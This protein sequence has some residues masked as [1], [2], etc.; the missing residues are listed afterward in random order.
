[1]CSIYY[2]DFGQKIFIRLLD[3]PFLPY[4][5]RHKTIVLMKKGLDLLLILCVFCLASCHRRP[6]YP[7]VLH[8]ADSLTYVAP[9]QA[10]QMLDSINEEMT[11]ADKP[12]R[13]YHQL[14]TVKAKDKA[15]IT[16]TSD[17]LMLSLVDYYE[18]GGDKSLLPEAYYYLG[19][20]YRDLNDAPRAL[21]AFQKAL[22]AV[23]KTP[24]SL[25]RLIHNQ[26]GWLYYRQK[27]YDDA[28]NSY[29]EGYRCDSLLK[30]SFEMSSDLV[31]IA[32]IHR[33]IDSFHDALNYLETAK[34][35][36]TKINSQF[37]LD[38]VDAQ[39]AAA[40]L[41]IGR[42]E[43]AKQLLQSPLKHVVRS[44][45]S[46][47]YSN[48]AKAYLHVGDK[49]SAS[50]YF[51]RVLEVGNI[52]AKRAAY[53]GLGDIALQSGHIKEAAEY[54]KQFKVLA[55]SAHQI[56]ASESVAQMKSL[57]DYQL[58]EKENM[59]LEARNSR[60]HYMTA[61]LICIGIILALSL[62][63]YHLYMQRKKALMEHRLQMM[64]DENLTY[65]HQEE[66][67]N[68]WKSEAPNLIMNSEVYANLERMASQ[69][70]V[71]SAEDWKAVEALLNE[72][73]PSYIPHL[74]ASC[75]MS[76][77]DFHACCLMK[78]KLSHTNIC[79]LTPLTST[80]ALSNMCRNLYE[81][82]HGKKGSTAD[83]ISYLDSL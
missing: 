79:T 8:E 44:N 68:R 39:I 37:M 57:Y 18:H 6:A 28:L 41:E 34:G 19:S 26:M 3:S 56:T 5:C 72:V 77:R 69:M 80:Q 51:N 53:E 23:D 40:Y 70:E 76:E 49:D 17:S 2:Q 13:M 42:Y 25:L 74:R 59:R 31:N 46:S 14:L 1:M 29:L 83:F 58:R 12:T 71:L 9:Q 30:D 61:L 43:E 15:Y 52:Y 63:V 78:L 45:I 33:V 24:S 55:D 16:H 38:E 36:A 73:Y 50:Y 11:G 82:I 81:R 64:T 4:L 7:P 20:T 10:L 27:M 62:I 66:A 21:G 60:L 75:K 54:Y 48:A 32:Y 47:V 65:K 35:I 22:D 67:R